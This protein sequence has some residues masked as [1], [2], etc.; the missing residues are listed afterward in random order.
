MRDTRP[1]DALE[2]FVLRGI[3]EVKLLQRR[4]TLDFP[5]FRVQARRPE[6]PHNHHAAS[7]LAQLR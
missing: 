1:H 6:S 7:L 4:E 3:E 2:T 5:L